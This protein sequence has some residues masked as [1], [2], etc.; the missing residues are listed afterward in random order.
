MK[1][2]LLASFFA[3]ASLAFA[4][5]GHKG[6]IEIEGLIQAMPAEGHVGEWKVG[7]KVVHVNAATVIKEKDGKAVVGKKV[8]VKGVIEENGLVT[9]TKIETENP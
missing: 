2:I 4:A 9:A 5:E 3:L 7:N 1:T 6:K 8:D